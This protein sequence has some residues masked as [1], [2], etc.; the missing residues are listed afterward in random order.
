MKVLKSR[1]YHWNIYQ[2]YQ[3]M[4]WLSWLMILKK[5]KLL[6]VHTMKTIKIWLSNVWMRMTLIELNGE[7]RFWKVH[8]VMFKLKSK[9]SFLIVGRLRKM[10]FNNLLFLKEVLSLWEFKISSRWLKLEVWLESRIRL[11]TKSIMRKDSFWRVKMMEQQ[12]KRWNYSME[13]EVPILKKS[14]KIKKSALT[15]TI[16]VIPTC[17]EEEFTLLKGHSIRIVTDILRKLKLRQ[18]LD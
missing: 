3:K 17:L 14:I 18:C 10:T 16:Q 8:I 9:L 1:R 5:N 4:I 15:S 6:N 13:Q 7:S 12:L 11:S 2:T